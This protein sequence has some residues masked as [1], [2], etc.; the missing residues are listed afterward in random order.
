M[1]AL[2]RLFTVA[3][4]AVTF[5][6]VVAFA[7]GAFA[8]WSEFLILGVGC[9]VAVL[10]GFIWI[11]RPQPVGVSR[12]LHPPRVTVGESAIGVVSVSNPLKRRVGPR[13]AEDTLGDRVVRLSI[14]ALDPGE[15]IEQPY[16][17]PAMRRGL[18]SVGPVR[19]TRSDPL[20]LL[21]RIQGQGSV[22]SLWVRPRT[23]QLPMIP[24]GWA[25]DLDGVT[26]DTSPRGSSAFHALREY[27][28]GDDLRHVHWRTT[29]RRNQLMVRHFVDTRRSQEVVLLDPLR[30]VYTEE[31]FEEAVSIVG[32]VC[33]SALN[34]QRPIE[35]LL[36]GQSSDAQATVLHPLDRLALVDRI[37]EVS[38]G[39]VFSIARKHVSA[40]S[41]FVIVTGDTEPKELINQARNLMRHGLVIVVCVKPGAQ[42]ERL[43]YGAGRV[44][45]VPDAESLASV[46]R[47]AGVA[48]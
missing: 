25:K 33:V 46:W 17:V 36:P 21:S 42:I 29:A 3:G 37:D 38:R 43:N 10:V 8:G 13:E 12:T 4:K 48:A 20:G 45:V 15:S 9:F 2:F 6:A 23:Y 1:R 28:Y 35:L 5:A 19:L 24:S 18:F 7:I 40:A 41:A 26:S 22:E 31:S 39:D 14:P 27:Q 34:G 16:T 47:L 30:S 44:I 11:S 32:S